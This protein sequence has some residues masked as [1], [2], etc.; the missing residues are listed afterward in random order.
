MLVLTTEQIKEASTK[1]VQNS[2]LQDTIWKQETKDA[3][4]SGVE[5]AEFFY[6]LQIEVILQKMNG[7]KERLAEIAGG[8]YV[9][10]N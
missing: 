7:Y 4:E 5:F 8:I 2:L 9:G 10:R 1:Y 3:F 6:K